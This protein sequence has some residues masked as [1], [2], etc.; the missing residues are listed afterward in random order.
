M[1][2]DIK[3]YL[4]NLKN[5]KDFDL[6]VTL[7]QKN[8]ELFNDI[9][10]TFENSHVEYIENTQGADIYPFMHVI[11][12]INLNDYQLIYKLHSKRDLLDSNTRINHIY[13]GK[14]LWRDFL[15]EAILGKN[16]VVRVLEKFN[17]N[18]NLGMYGFS[19]LLINIPSKKMNY[20]P[21]ADYLY[22]KYKQKLNLKKSDNFK[23]YAGPI[24]VIRAEIL[25]II[26]NI[27]TIED[28]STTDKKFSQLAYDMEALFGYLT[29]MQG[30]SFEDEHNL[31]YFC[32]K[33]LSH[34]ITKNIYINFVNNF[35]FGRK[36]V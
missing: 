23:F 21:Q 22:E 12:K 30:Y 36:I 32:L 10:N 13:I 5:I 16:Q 3:N 31:K 8:P 6:Y 20:L 34:K 18:K 19:P 17:N 28:F 7:T 33:F 4:L 35:I 27:F 9:N 24:F 26:K 2:N 1:W 14:N 29:E 15:Y 25:K 11:N